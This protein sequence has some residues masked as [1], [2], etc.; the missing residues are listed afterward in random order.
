MVKKSVEI[1]AEIQTDHIIWL[2]LINKVGHLG[3]KGN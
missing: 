2:P 3:I 1:V